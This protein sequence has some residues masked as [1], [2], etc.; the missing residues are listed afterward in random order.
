MSISPPAPPASTVP[1]SPSPPV[2]EKVHCVSEKLYPNSNTSKTQILSDN[3]N[4]AGIY[5]WENL[6][7]GKRYIGSAVDLYFRLSF[8][9]SCKAMKN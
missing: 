6:P 4:K 8:Y 3:K 1:S 9:F 5:M 2:P 7:N